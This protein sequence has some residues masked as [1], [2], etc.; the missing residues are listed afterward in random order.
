MDC[1]IL[2]CCACHVA[3]LVF[4]PYSACSI[5]T[6]VPALSGPNLGPAVVYTFSQAGIF[7]YAL[8]M[9]MDLLQCH[10]KLQ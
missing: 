7:R 1:S 2:V 10:L 8:P 4:S 9:S 6:G 5:S 3:P